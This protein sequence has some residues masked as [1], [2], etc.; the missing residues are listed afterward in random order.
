[1]VTVAVFLMAPTTLVT[2]ATLPM[3]YAATTYAVAAS[4][5]TNAR[6]STKVM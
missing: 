5:V 4:W 1:M 6:A 2:L 3:R